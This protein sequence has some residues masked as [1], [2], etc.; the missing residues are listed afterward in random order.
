M[1]AS[2]A[3]VL[4]IP[5]RCVVV[6]GDAYLCDPSVYRDQNTGPVAGP[7]AFAPLIDPVLQ[8]KLELAGYTLAAAAAMRVTSG[9]RVDTHVTETRDNA[10]PT[11]TTVAAVTPGTALLDLAPPDIVAVAQSLHLAA[12]VSS[13]LR[14]SSAKYGGKQLELSVEMQGLD[15]REPVW[16]VTCSQLFLDSVAT[17]ALL[18]N[19]AGNGILAAVAP[20]NLL[21]RSR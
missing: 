16:A 14:I 4:V 15:Q 6:D 10:L 3:A 18:G 11:G 12:I 20:D 8:L 7:H 19:C 17:S 2:G 5:T 13:T 1:R 9:D 21:G